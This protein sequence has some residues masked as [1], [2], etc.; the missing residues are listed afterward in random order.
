[1]VQ[2]IPVEEFEH[3][4]AVFGD[5]NV[6]H[7]GIPFA[8]A[9]EGMTVADLSASGVS[10]AETGR[11]NAAYW[12]SRAPHGN[13]SRRGS[14][15]LNMSLRGVNFPFRGTLSLRTVTHEI[16]QTRS[17]PSEGQFATLSRATAHHSSISSLLIYSSANN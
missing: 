11:P 7:V 3:F 8:Q 12:A 6:G 17:N 2:T 9:V 10:Q 4:K 1:M 15:C 14:A 5:G 13:A 16:V